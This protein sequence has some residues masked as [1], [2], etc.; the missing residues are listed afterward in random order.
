MSDVDLARDL[1][2]GHHTELRPLG[3]CCR[4]PRGCGTMGED[5]SFTLLDLHKSLTSITTWRRLEISTTTMSPFLGREHV[6]GC[7]L[8]ELETDSMGLKPKYSHQSLVA[9]LQ[10]PIA[11]QAEQ[12]R[13]GWGSIASVSTCLNK[14]IPIVP[15][16]F[17]DSWSRFS[18][19]WK[20]WN[21]CTKCVFCYCWSIPLFLS[22]K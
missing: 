22:L 5:R 9:H 15:E 16:S 19:K 14:S 10:K 20:N 4:Y 12:N 6:L 1:E 21:W 8:V 11:P 7:S 17:K 18:K 2:G 3:Y 13:K